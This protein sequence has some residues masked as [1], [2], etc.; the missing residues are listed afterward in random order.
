MENDWVVYTAQSLY[1]KEV[2]N[3][4]CPK[5]G[6]YSSRSYSGLCQGCYVYFR[7]GGKV[8]DLPAPGTIG[9]DPSGKVICHICGR[10]FQ[11]LGSHV[12]ESHSMTIEEYKEKFGLCRNAR[13]TEKQY[14]A[15]MHDLA[16]K[17][18]MDKIL[19]SIGEKTRIKPGEKDK[20][21]GKETRLQENL[22][23]RLRSVKK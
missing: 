6:K 22:Q 20:R 1:Y 7:D 12:T 9:Y 2:Y 17:S 19:P 16:I 4:H 10:S 13:T 11:R 18:G 21:L 23:K 3:L 5:C 15:K 14:S 8:F